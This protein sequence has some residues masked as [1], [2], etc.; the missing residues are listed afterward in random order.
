MLEGNHPLGK[1]AVVRPL[2]QL[3]LGRT[4]QDGEGLCSCASDGLFA[5]HRAQQQ[6]G[7]QAVQVAL[8]L[9]ASRAEG[10]RQRMQAGRRHLGVRLTCHTELKVSQALAVTQW[11]P[12]L[13]PLYS[14]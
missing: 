10:C 13:A 2:A 11:S 4:W 12:S 5:V 1:E 14:M 6:R 3:L 7:D 9:G 8:Q